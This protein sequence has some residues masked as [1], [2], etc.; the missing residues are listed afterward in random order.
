MCAKEKPPVH[1]LVSMTLLL[2]VSLFASAVASSRADI[3]WETYWPGDDDE[4]IDAINEGELNF[5]DKPTDKPVHHHHNKITVLKSSIKTG[6]IKLQQCHDNLDIFPRVQIVYKQ[7]KIRNLRITEHNNIGEAR[8]EGHTVQLTDVKKHAR[9]CIEAESRAL[10]AQDDGS[11]VMQNGPFMRKFLDGYF[12]MRVSIDIQLPANLS[13]VAIE[14]VEQ[15]GFTVT[16]GKQR[17]QLDTWFEGRL[18]TQI[19]FELVPE[20]TILTTRKES[21]PALQSP[22]AL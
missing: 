10:I 5:L 1:L 17:L 3:D 6:W 20:T 7:G 21:E 4:V 8:V 12:P 22:L 9:L 13:F 18:M 16:R 15:K 14:P 19:R 2:L 11:F